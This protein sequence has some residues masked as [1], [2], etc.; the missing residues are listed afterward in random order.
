MAI[1]VSHHRPV[2]RPTEY[3]LND[4]PV[5]SLGRFSYI[6]GQAWLHFYAELS[7][8]RIGSFCSVATNT[9]FFLRANHHPEW[10]TTYAMELIPWP[11]ETPKPA[12]VHARL[13]GDIEIGSDVWVGEGARFMPGAT[14]GHGAVIGAGTVVTKTVPPYALFAGNPGRVRKLRF[15][16]ADIE[17]LL[18]LNWWDWPTEKI[19]GL[20]PL[21]CSP[22]LD[23]LRRA[24]DG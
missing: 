3:T 23:Q 1:P 20:A 13:K 12:A 19:R 21:L 10:L 9:G 5:L 17:F 7:S 18:Q 8:I 24:V 11:E 16:E 22:D 15:D 6:D 4:Y 14:V 2:D